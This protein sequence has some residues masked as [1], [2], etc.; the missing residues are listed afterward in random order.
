MSGTEGDIP[1]GEGFYLDTSMMV[2]GSY[3]VSGSSEVADAC[4]EKC[5]PEGLVSFCGQRAVAEF[6]MMNAM[7][8]GG[9]QDTMFEVEVH[10][11]G[12]KR[13]FLGK[14]HCGATVTT[15][16]VAILPIDPEAE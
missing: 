1:L 3:T 13:R 11:D 5:N 8:G 4:W 7:G 16:M 9:K 14:K 6:C 10:C 12:P 15:K 2:T